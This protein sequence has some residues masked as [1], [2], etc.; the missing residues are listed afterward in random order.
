MEIEITEPG[1]HYHIYNRGINR[2]NIFIED[3]HNYKF[4]SLCKKYIPLQ[5]DVL[6]Y[7]LLPNY[8][9]M[10]VY[11]HEYQAG[12]LNPVRVELNKGY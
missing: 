8:F 9:H 10:A 7:C 6:A 5:S 1:Y 2:E 11:I 4:L 3:E 12:Y